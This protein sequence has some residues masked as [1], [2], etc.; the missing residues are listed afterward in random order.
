MP[1][2]KAFPYKLHTFLLLLLL[3]IYFGCRELNSDNVKGITVQ[4]DSNKKTIFQPKH[5]FMSKFLCLKGNNTDN[6]CTRKLLSNGTAAIVDF[7]A[8]LSLFF[9]H[10]VHLGRFQLLIEEK[11]YIIPKSNQ[12]HLL[13]FL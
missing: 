1:Y 5:A 11:L 3:E 8:S 6:C 2:W 9:S 13:D 7:A 12:L 10:I 4:S